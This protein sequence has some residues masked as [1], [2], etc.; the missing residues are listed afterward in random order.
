M[1]RSML[2]G[3]DGSSYSTAAVEL[4]IRWARRSNALLVGLGIIDEPGIVQPVAIPPGGAAFQQSRNQT[5]LADARHKVEAYLE[6]F[7]LRCAEAGVSSK[8]LEDVGDP[9]DR[10]MLEAQC[11]DLIL[12]GRETHFAF[13]TQAGAD[14]ALRHVVQFGPRPVVAVPEKPAGGNTVVVAYDGSAQAARALQ[15]FQAVGW[16][17]SSP[18]HVVS[19]HAEHREAARCA[20]R[21]V[22]FLGFH[23]IKAEPHALAGS[24]NTPGLLLEQA[25]R[26]DAG[27][28]VMGAYGQPR[29]KELFFGSVTRTML[30]ESDLPLFL[31]H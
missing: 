20:D 24:E 25:R 7:T 12:L 31:D 4:G 2:V 8:V 28:V 13:E 11:Y 26:L 22:E 17:G 30:R 19:V 18:I 9:A 5:L 10:I 16:D 21:A 15:A 14:D 6:Q 29:W 3:L 23:G 27:L 1:P